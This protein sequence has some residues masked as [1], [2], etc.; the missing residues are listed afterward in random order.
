MSRLE[1]ASTCSKREA[2]QFAFAIDSE[3]GNVDAQSR[4]SSY[5]GGW[6]F[7]RRSGNSHCVT[8]EATNCSSIA[9]IISKNR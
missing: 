9:A 8:R 1:T 4:R 3:A 2:A 7:V 6:S 5:G